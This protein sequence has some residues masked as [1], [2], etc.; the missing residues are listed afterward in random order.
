MRVRIAPSILT[1]D[2]GRLSEQIA[3]AEKGGADLL[4]LDVMD[5]RFVP[6]I[7]FGPL[8][9]ASIHRATR[10][11]IEAHLMVAEPTAQLEPMAAAGASRLIPHMEAIGNEEGSA[12]RLVEAIHALGCEAALAISPETP[13]EALAPLLDTLDGVTVMTV[14]PGRGGQSFLPEMLPKVTML[15]TLIDERGLRTSLEV[16]GGVKAQNASACVA[17]GADT[18]VAGSAVYNDIETPQQ[19]LSTLRKHSVGS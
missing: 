19:A 15:R 5:G 3:A 8:I 18:L 2:F 11:P 12:T 13:A 4:H 17:A 14:H 10:L 7:T 6:S 16:D 9:V 1:I